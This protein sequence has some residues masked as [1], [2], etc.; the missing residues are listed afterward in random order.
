MAHPDFSYATISELGHA[1]RSGAVS[2]VELTTNALE[3]IESLNAKLHAFI[4]LTPERALAEA[5]AA[6]TAFR[7]RQ[8]LG[9]LF[10]IPYA[11]KDI[12]DVEGQPTTAGSRLLADNVAVRDC[13][14]VHKLKQCGM[15]HIGKNHL[16]QFASDIVGINHDQGTPHNPWAKVPHVPGGSSSG[17]AVAVAAGLVPFAMGSD[18]GGSIRTPAALCGVVGLKTTVGRISRAGVYPLSATFDSIG[19]LARSVKDAAIVCSAIQGEDAYDDATMRVPDQEM[20]SGLDSGVADLKIAMGESVFFDDVDHAIE[21]AVRAGGEVLRMLGAHVFSMELPEIEEAEAIPERFLGMAVEAYQSNKVLLEGRAG[22][23]DPIVN[24]MFRGKTVAAPDYFALLQ[25]RDRLRRGVCERLSDVDAVL[26]PTVATPAHPTHVVDADEETYSRHQA[27]YV[28]NTTLGNFLG[29]CG[30]SVPCGF[31]AE[32]LPIGM[33]VYA[34][35][36]EEAAALRVAHAY[37]QATDWH[38]R[39]PDLRWASRG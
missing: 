6:E 13:T 7:S 10:G 16:V 25:H 32:G 21:E 9:P 31:T 2:P 14:V 34:R 23:I 17:S 3:R 8:I 4:T 27:K 28:R 19:L 18:T 22:V 1:L 5:K 29:L 26:V 12:F 37:E 15:I 35:P 11:V 38:R 24:W 33:M 30:V 36:F 39:Q 20:L